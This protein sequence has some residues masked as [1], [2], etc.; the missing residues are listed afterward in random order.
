MKIKQSS[1]SLHC[2]KSIK[3]EQNLYKINEEP[4]NRTSIEALTS[5]VW[6]KEYLN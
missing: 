5:R 1:L 2:K 3:T 6:L 4:L